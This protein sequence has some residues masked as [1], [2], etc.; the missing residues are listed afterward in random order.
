MTHISTIQHPSHPHWPHY[1][2]ARSTD[3]KRAYGS[4]AIC[5]E[6]HPG[7]FRTGYGL[8][9]T[10]CYR[11]AL[12]SAICTHCHRRK[13]RAKP[14]DPAPWCAT[15]LFQR[16]VTETR[17]VTCEDLLKQVAQ[18][19]DEGPICS[20]CYLR[21]RPEK[22]CAYCGLV[23]R[24]VATQS[25][26]GDGRPICHRCIY[27]RLPKC[28]ECKSR[29]RPITGP[30]D[31]TNAAICP[32]CA[33]GERPKVRCACGAWTRQFGHQPARCINCA[34]K[35]EVIPKTR[36][37][38]LQGLRQTWVKDLFVEYCETL[39][40]RFRWATSIPKML[41]T[42]FDIFAG[43]DRA[44]AA[45]SGVNE[46]TLASALGSTLFRHRTRLLRWMVNQSLIAPL[47]PV[48]R[49]WALL[50]WKLKS[51]TDSRT[52]PWLVHTITAFHDDLVR[53]RDRYVRKHHKRTRAPLQARS[54][55]QNV[56]AARDF[57]VSVEQWGIHEVTAIQQSHMDQY[58]ASHRRPLTEL[59]RFVRFLNRRTSRFKRLKL[60]RPRRISG[61]VRPLTA[62]QFDDLLIRMLQ[63][64]T[65]IELRYMLMTLFCLL[66]AQFPKTVVALRQDQIREAAGQWE[67]C[68][69]KVWLAIPEPMGALLTRWQ[70][71]RRE[72]S[73]MDATGSSPHLFPGKRASAWTSVGSFNDWLVKHGVRPK[74]LFVSG[75]ANLC[76]HGMEFATVARDAYGVNPA[77]AVRYLAEFH[78]AK[79]QVA[80]RQVRASAALRR[81]SRSK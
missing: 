34:I 25:I 20:K 62:D 77:T 33:S 19:L 29:Y 2:S 56:R 32:K 68:P 48:D 73:A 15:C 5:A 7:L 36:D 51:L 28:T 50:P 49:E 8:V 23:H 79:A 59:G 53:E 67:F 52:A 12:I 13:V 42:D 69:A 39:C 6:V 60:S 16:L 9:C 17:C 22:R 64:Q 21:R 76:R 41:R 55:F 38:L 70:A 37:R 26:Y 40:R 1:P 30:T 72:Q 63:P 45:Q 66:F 58:A 54:A 31:S 71:S 43:M 46:C 4:C 78:P 74:Q 35:A 75:F 18:W 61:L 14:D 44:F 24:S 11:T 10:H 27:K 47:S 65:H 80:A 81:R 57:L 3:G